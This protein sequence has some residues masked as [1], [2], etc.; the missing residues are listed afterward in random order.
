MIYNL[1][2]INGIPVDFSFVKSIYVINKHVDT[3]KN[4]K[5]KKQ[6]IK[7]HIIIQPPEY[8]YDDLSN[9]RFELN[10]NIKQLIISFLKEVIVEAFDIMK[11]KQKFIPSIYNTLEN[12]FEKYNKDTALMKL[13]F[14]MMYNGVDNLVIEPTIDTQL[15]FQCNSEY[16]L[17]S[18]LCYVST[19]FPNVVIYYHSHG[20]IDNNRFSNK[21]VNQSYKIMN[22]RILSNGNK[23]SDTSQQIA[24][25]IRQVLQNII[26]FK[27]VR[28]SYM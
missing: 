16:L 12:N 26:Q 23:I 6:V 8:L 15:S 11:V 13:V 2:A 1:E 7:N 14:S 24:V 17:Q 3:K 28:S 19:I 20:I 4:N 21:M 22:Q 9:T 25:S 5:S 27:L 10:K 18:M